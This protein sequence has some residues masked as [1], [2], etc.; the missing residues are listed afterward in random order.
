M[1]DAMKI[2]VLGTSMVG[3]AI[4]SKRVAVGHEVIMGSRELRNAT[5]QTHF[6]PAV[7][8]RPSGEDF[9]RA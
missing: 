2:G 1:G 3:H 6:P 4:V 5:L 8:V 9:F 7:R